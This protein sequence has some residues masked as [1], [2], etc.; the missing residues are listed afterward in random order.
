MG[1]RV[2]GV[3]EASLTSDVFV[4]CM[5][6]AVAGQSMSFRSRRKVEG[7]GGGEGG[8]GRARIFTRDEMIRVGV[9]TSKNEKRGR[10]VFRGFRAP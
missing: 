10:V 5:L 4:A 8:G 9:A 3:A 1:F 7:Q 6:D 2:E